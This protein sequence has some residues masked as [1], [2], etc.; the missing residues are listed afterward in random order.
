MIGQ[1]RVLQPGEVI[2]H[3]NDDSGWRTMCMERIDSCCVR[4]K[5]SCRKACVHL[6]QDGSV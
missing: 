2:I 5:K 1:V 3:M 6:C 4:V